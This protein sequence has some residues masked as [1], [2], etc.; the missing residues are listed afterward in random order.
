MQG[1]PR[2]NEGLNAGKHCMCCVCAEVVEVE[3]LCIGEGLTQ[4]GGV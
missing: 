4:I 2:G 1:L 3:V